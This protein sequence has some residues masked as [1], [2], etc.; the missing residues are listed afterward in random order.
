M[1]IKKYIIFGNFALE[2]LAPDGNTNLIGHLYPLSENVIIRLNKSG[3]DEADFHYF[4]KAKSPIPVDTE[5]HPESFWRNF[6]GSYFRVTYEG[7]KYDIDSSNVT[8][9]IVKQEPVG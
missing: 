7:H 9:K 4:R 1:N 5:I 3:Y 6:Y 8:I 2:T